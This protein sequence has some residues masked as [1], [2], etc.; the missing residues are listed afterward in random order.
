[1]EGFLISSLIILTI[2]ITATIKTISN[3]MIR[4]KLFIALSSPLAN[5]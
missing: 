2:K 3:I 4:S 1:M 5:F